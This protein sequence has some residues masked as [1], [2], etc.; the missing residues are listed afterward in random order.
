MAETVTFNNRIFPVR[1]VDI[2]G[3]GNGLAIATVEL[4]GQLMD[5]E[6]PDYVSEEAKAL[7]ESV[8]FYVDKQEIGMPEDEL[9]EVVLYHLR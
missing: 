4:S 5:A 2:P 9:V 6:G 8:F 7:D 1:T 3:Y